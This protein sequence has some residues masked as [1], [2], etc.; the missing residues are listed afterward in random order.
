M[1]KFLM[2]LSLLFCNTVC[3]DTINLHWLNDDGTTYQN[4]TCT[5]DS[6]LNI[7]TTPP[8]KYGYTFTGWK[9]ANYIPIEYLE[10]TGTQY[11]DT[12]YVYNTNSRLSLSVKIGR[13]AQYISGEKA[14][15][16]N[17]RN[18]ASIGCGIFYN[19]GLIRCFNAPWKSENI[20]AQDTN[21][22]SDTIII[23][24]WFGSDGFYC[25]FANSPKTGNEYNTQSSFSILLFSRWEL[26]SE[27]NF[28]GKIYYA[29]IYDNN[30]LVRDMIPVLDLNGTPC[31][32]D[33]VTQQFFYNQ[34]TGQFIA[35]PAL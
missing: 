7:P 9:M 11:I 26:E 18:S 16:T 30:I 29:K 8:T 5:V 24:G 20:N 33:K 23:N 35:G 28:P 3:A 12:G 34:G 4:S 10:S 2:L 6:D 17:A 1:K 21:M 25:D 19:N 27:Y 31:L 32:Y 15:I 14:I 22:L 13:P